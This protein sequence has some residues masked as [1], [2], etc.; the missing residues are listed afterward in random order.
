MASVVTG[1]VAEIRAPNARHSPRENWSAL[2]SAAGT[3]RTQNATTTVETVVP[4]NACART[5]T[6]LSKNCRVRIA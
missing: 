3:K 2:P 4:T 1:S 5:R 6:M